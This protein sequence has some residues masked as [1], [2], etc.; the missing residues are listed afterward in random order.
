[1][2]KTLLICI[3]AAFSVAG[4]AQNVDKEYSLAEVR[5]SDDLEYE[6]YTY[7]SDLL[8]EATD[9]L[10]E[11]G[12]EVKDSLS[13]DAAKNP[14]KLDRYQLLN[15]SWTHVSYIDYTYDANGNRLSR[16]NYN[17]F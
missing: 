15:G 3:T 2:K 9:I 10:F 4:F 14:I 7:N 1:M 8:L 12:I 17:S 16:S 13:Y 5:S 11:D 6:R